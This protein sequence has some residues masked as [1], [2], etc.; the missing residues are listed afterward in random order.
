MKST[1]RLE[2]TVSVDYVY[3]KPVEGRVTFKFGYGNLNSQVE[4]I[5][6]SKDKPL[7]NGKSN[8]SFDIV[9][10]H[11]ISPN[12]LFDSN[13]R[14]IVEVEVIEFETSKKVKKLFSKGLFTKVAF[15]FSFDETINSF[16]PGLENKFIARLYYANDKIA[17]NIPVNVEIPE[18]NLVKR[19]N[20][21]ENGYLNLSFIVDDR[22]DQIKVDLKTSDVSFDYLEQL[23]ETKILQ[24][25]Q[26]PTGGYLLIDKVNRDYQV[27]DKFEAD[28]ILNNFDYKQISSFNYYLISSSGNLIDAKS[29]KYFEKIKFELKTEHHPQIT[30]IVIGQAILNKITNKTE[31]KTNDILLTDTIQINVDLPL[32]CGIKTHLLTIDGKLKDSDLSKVSVFKPGDEVSLEFNSAIDQQLS[33]IGVDEAIYALSSNTLL[34]KSKLKKLYKDNNLICGRGGYTYSD[35][36]LNSGLILFDP[37]NTTNHNPISSLCKGYTKNLLNSKKK[38]NL[39]GSNRIKRYSDDFK[40]IENSYDYSKDKNARY[41]CLLGIQI[42]KSNNYPNMCEDKLNVLKKHVNDSKCIKAFKNCCDTN[43]PKSDKQKVYVISAYPVSMA[44]SNKE[45]ND[46]VHI[47]EDDDKEQATHIRDDFRETW[48][49]DIIPLEK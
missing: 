14:F 9:E 3:G 43:P 40:S 34:A 24:K 27:G 36:L 16:K 26:S 47:A 13:K 5:G 12:N 19:L 48:L 33:L 38:K 6:K 10:F 17:P 1:K 42:S 11:I 23:S 28:F 30:L 39:K 29:I 44:D 8:F 46:F 21:D 25:Q 41:C 45:R 18:I 15:K 2:G 49:F 4:F 7:Y 35:V 22:L 20:T 32:D 37:D 31:F